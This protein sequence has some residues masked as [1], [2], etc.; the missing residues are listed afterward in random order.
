MEFSTKVMEKMSAML[1]EEL[2]PYSEELAAEGGVMGIE[3]EMRSLLQQV[4]AKGLGK[5]LSGQDVR[6]QRKRQIACPC[7]KQADYV[8]T[9]TA[10]VLSVFGWVSYDRGYYLCADCQ[11]GQAPL[12]GELGLSAGQVTAGLGSLLA[13]SA[14]T[15]YLYGQTDQSS[16][17]ESGAADFGAAERRWA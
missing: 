17:K 10:K 9:R 6:K 11:K 16:G 3:E 12:D 8:R 1:A 15:N 14:P 5:V 13:P 2:Q 4:G 7:G